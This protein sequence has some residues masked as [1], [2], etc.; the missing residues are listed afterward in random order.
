MNVPSGRKERA[1]M[2]GITP[3]KMRSRVP[4]AYVGAM[5]PFGAFP[6]ILK[7]MRND[8]DEIVSRFYGD[9]PFPV[10]VIP[11]G[12]PW[13]VT[14]Q[15]KPNEIV[16]EAEAPGFEAGDFDVQV[17]DHELILDAAKKS[18][19]KK[20]GK[21]HEVHEQKY[22]ESVTLPRGI[23]TEKVEAKYH[24]GVLTI[25]FPKTEKVKGRKVAIT[26]G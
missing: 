17:R 21:Y 18:K 3:R 20:E 11:T 10:S 13:E 25:S 14:V 22:H 24:N 7:R 16:V 9:L 8:F 6:A 15:D 26:G 5:T 4:V 19:T 1:T 2:F 12:W 23:D